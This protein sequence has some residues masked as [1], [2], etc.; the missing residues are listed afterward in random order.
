MQ[1]AQSVDRWSVG[2]GESASVS[3]ALAARTDTRQYDALITATE[4]PTMGMQIV[5]AWRLY[6]D[7]PG[8]PTAALGAF[9]ARFGLEVI[10]GGSVRGLFVPRF[11]GM[12]DQIVGLAGEPK[13]CT[14]SAM[15]RK[16][17]NGP[18]T[19]EWAYAIDDAAYR[20]YVT[21]NR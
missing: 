17:G 20:R 5:Q 18:L 15:M 9:I 21:T 19:V 3:I 16:D 10:V 14:M 1:D 11:T 13:S 4:T 6:G 7:W 12:A 2:E 8:S